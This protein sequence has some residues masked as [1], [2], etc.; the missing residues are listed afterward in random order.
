MKIAI[1]KHTYQPDLQGMETPRIYDADYDTLDE[2]AAQIAEWDNEIYVTEH[3]ESGRPTYLVVDDLA[4]DYVNG[5]RNQDMSN[6]DWSD[7]DCECG[8][9]NDCCTMAILQDRDYLLG[10]ALYKS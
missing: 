10:A 7:A 6:Y 3:N 9:C 4:A 1:L 8:E 5:G 2:A